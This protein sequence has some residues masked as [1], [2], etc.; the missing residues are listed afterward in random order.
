MK[1]T[2]DPHAQA[3]YIAIRS[4]K[5]LKTLATP[6]DSVHLDILTS[7]EVGGI[8]ILGVSQVPEVHELRR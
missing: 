3:V 4:G 2:Y 6:D 7:G 1:I 8:E 5:H